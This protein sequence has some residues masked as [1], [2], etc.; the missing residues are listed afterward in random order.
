MG[1][2]AENDETE[3]HRLAS[4]IEG[5]ELD[6][7]IAV[8]SAD[9]IAGRNAI[10]GPCTVKAALKQYYD[11]TSPARKQLCLILSTYAEDPEE[12]KKLQVL[13]S[14]DPDEQE[15]YLKWIVQDLR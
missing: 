13:A 15:E 9:D 7:I 10:V 1:V 11:I 14:D 12:K 8:Y 5:A 2:Y 6:K 4:K 3:V